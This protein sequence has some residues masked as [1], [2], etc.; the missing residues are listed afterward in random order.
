MGSSD[1]NKQ[2]EKVCQK[3]KITNKDK[4]TKFHRYLNS[5][6]YSD[7]SDNFTYQEL[8]EVGKEFLENEH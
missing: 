8:L 2:F 6:L 4:K 7:I 1:K 5:I 3:L